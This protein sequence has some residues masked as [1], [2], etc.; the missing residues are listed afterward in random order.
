MNILL[1][2]VNLDS[3]SGPNS[4]GKKLKKELDYNHFVSTSLEAFS[5]KHIDI[6]ISFI[7]ANFKLAPLVQR[8]DGI[9][10]NSEQDF[11]TLNSPI[12]STYRV[13]DGVI[14]QSNFN[15]D[16]TRHY[17]GVSKKSFVIRNGTDLDAISKISPIDNNNLDN[18]ENVWTCA[19]SWRPHKR[20]GENIRYFIENSGEND[21]LVVAGNNPDKI[22]SHNRIFYAG[23]LDWNTLISLYKKSKYFIHLAWLDHCPNVVV[24]ARAA[25]CH[26]IC[27]SAGGTREI[28]G[29]NSTI[30]IEDDWDFTPVKLYSPPKMDFT[31]RE[32][33]DFES[34]IDIK[35]VSKEYLKVFEEISR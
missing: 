15:K 2:N 35:N 28:A 3:R 24:D 4:F 13:A 17:F 23:D 9:Y 18:F 12:E 6:Q 7:A 27:S 11:N 21:C 30:I 1:D 31:K 8:L 33:G 26:I 5:N 19:S 22:M 25:G 16:L 14:F 10:F 34:D 20:L 29:K 32:K